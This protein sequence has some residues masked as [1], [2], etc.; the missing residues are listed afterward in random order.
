MTMPLSLYDNTIMVL[1]S[2]KMIGRVLVLSKKRGKKR[3]FT[4]SLSANV[5]STTLFAGL[6]LVRTEY[7][8]KNEGEYENLK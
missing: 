5:W 1:L 3:S 6:N 7:N 4:Y 2:D 8:L